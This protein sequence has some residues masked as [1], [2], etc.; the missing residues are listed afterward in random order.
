MVVLLVTFAFWSVRTPSSETQGQSVRSGEKAERKF[1]STGKRAPGYRLSLNYFQK[2]KP[3]L[4]PDWAQKMLCIIMPNRRTV[5]PEFFLWVRTRRLL[6]LHTCPVRSPSLCMQWKLLFSTFLS[7]NKRTTDESKKR[8]GCV[9]SVF[10]GSQFIVNNRQFKMRRWRESQI[11]NSLTM[12]NNKFAGASRFLY[13]SLLS[14]ARL[15]VKMPNFM[16]CEGRKQAMTKFILFM[17]FD[18]VDRNSA[19]EEFSCIWQSKRVGI[20]TTETE[21]MWNSLFHVTFPSWCLLKTLY[22]YIYARRGWCK[23][24]YLF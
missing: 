10:D 16:F 17:N 19:P 22:N 21:K 6:F 13:I 2:F 24:Q 12:Q 20:I 3:M 15:P 8:L 11:S 7:R 9:H 1:S 18:M 14:T 5:S 23:H 4:A